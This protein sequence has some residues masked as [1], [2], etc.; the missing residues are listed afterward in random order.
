MPVANLSGEKLRRIQINS[1]LRRAE[2]K[3]EAVIPS[4]NGG[5]SPL[6]KGPNASAKIRKC[7][8]LWLQSAAQNAL[9]ISSPI[10]YLSG[11]LQEIFTKSVSFYAQQHA[12][13]HSCPGFKAKFVTR[14]NGELFSSNRELICLRRDLILPDQVLLSVTC[15][16]H[17]IFCPWINSMVKEC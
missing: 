1:P 6:S 2:R 11:N 3:S 10:P 9:Y 7:G 13:A 4:K 17:T 16:H 15:Q 8:W 14:H 12:T 5:K